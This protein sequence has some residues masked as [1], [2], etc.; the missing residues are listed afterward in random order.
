MRSKTLF[1]VMEIRID[2]IEVS[3]F[4]EVRV[5]PYCWVFF[6]PR[7]SGANE[8]ENHKKRFYKNI[9]FKSVHT[10]CIEKKVP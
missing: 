9:H 5:Y 10:V 2:A 3:Y 6:G 7:V 8:S 4:C 1:W